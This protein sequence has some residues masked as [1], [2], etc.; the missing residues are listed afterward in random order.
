VSSV[1]R[2][3]GKDV[4][5]KMTRGLLLK[6]RWERL[7]NYPPPL[8]ALLKTSPSINTRERWER[9]LNYP[10]PRVFYT[11]YHEGNA[12]MRKVWYRKPSDVKDFGGANPPDY[13]KPTI[14]QPSLVH[15]TSMN[16][17]FHKAAAAHTRGFLF[18]SSINPSFHQPLLFLFLH[19]MSFPSV[20]SFLLVM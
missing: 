17:P 19:F 13:P 4:M 11:I 9:L 14:D 15:L 16:N 3:R 1:L 8:P 12:E 18:L 5:Q 6:E 20:S 7:L 10:P 2:K